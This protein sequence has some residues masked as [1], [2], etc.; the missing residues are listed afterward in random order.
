MIETMKRKP[1]YLLSAVLLMAWPLMAQTAEDMT[2]P[3]PVNQPAQ[4]PGGRRLAG[5]AETPWMS[6]YSQVKDRFTTLSESAASVDRIE[7]LMAVRNRYILIKRN[8]VLYRYNFYKTPYEVQKLTNH[9]LQKEQWEEEEAV[10][11][12]V[13]IIQPFIAADAINKKLEAAY[14]PRTRSTVKPETLRGADIWELEGGFIFQWYEPYNKQPYTRTIDYISAE[15]AARILK[16]REEYF[17][18]QERDLLRKMIV[19]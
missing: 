16:E 13:K 17:T 10:L 1:T 12:Q 6:S 11:Y 3:D 8:D 7:V 2:V 18:A 5:F 14:G 9:D 4:D 19:R 15:L